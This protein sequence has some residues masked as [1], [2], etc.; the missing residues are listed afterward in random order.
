MSINRFY[1][2]TS[3]MLLIVLPTYIYHHHHHLYSTSI[4]PSSCLS[5]SLRILSS[6]EYTYYDDNDN[7]SVYR[8]SSQ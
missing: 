8:L 6:N 7:L 4:L 1:L 5:V 3:L 2:Y